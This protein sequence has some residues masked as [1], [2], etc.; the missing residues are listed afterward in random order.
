MIKT[1]SFVLLAYIISLT[2]IHASNT[3]SITNEEATKKSLEYKQKYAVDCGAGYYSPG[4]AGYDISFLLPEEWRNAG[5]P[6]TAQDAQY[7]TLWIPDTLS[8]TTFNLGIH[9]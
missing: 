9:D 7:N 8:G 6:F 2:F 4:F 5:T 3:A 1:I